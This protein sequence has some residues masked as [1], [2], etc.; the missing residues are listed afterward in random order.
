MAVVPLLPNV[1][2]RII[3]TWSL[4]L[5]GLLVYMVCWFVMSLIFMPIL[6]VFTTAYAISAPWDSIVTL[7][8]NVFLWHPLFAIFG[9]ILY[10]ILNSS[11]KDIQTWA[12]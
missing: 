1:R 12:E 2:S 10:G 3:F 9:W 4:V 7:L 6:D 8:R 11:R 5:L